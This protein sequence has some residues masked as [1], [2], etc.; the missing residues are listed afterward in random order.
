MKTTKTALPKAQKGC[1]YKK[2][3]RVNARRKFWNSDAGQA[4]KKIGIGV[5]TAGAAIGAYAKN[6]F[7]VKD[8]V[9]DLMGQK[10]GGTV[11]TLTKKQNGGPAIAKPMPS[12]RPKTYPRGLAPT[13]KPQINANGNPGKE[14]YKPY[15]RP[16]RPSMSTADYKAKAIARYGSEEN[17]R[18]A[19]AIQK[20]GGATKS[21]V[22]K[23][24]GGATWTDAAY[25]GVTKTTPTRGGGTKEKSFTKL[26]GYAGQS[27]YLTKTKRDA[28]GVVIKETKK[29]ISPKRVD[30]VEKRVESKIQRKGGPVKT[31]KRGGLVA[32]KR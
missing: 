15:A 22:R 26:N 16:S 20:K 23:Q 27:G 21:L 29:S 5:G 3:Q 11:K 9:K 12:P 1:N 6:A 10:K 19:K 4:V 2:A 32:R 14:G 13:P 17:A 8:K 24:K 18:S 25:Q 31:M 7:G 28:D 30:R